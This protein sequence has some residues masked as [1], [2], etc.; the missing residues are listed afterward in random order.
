MTIFAIFSKQG[1]NMACGTQ[2]LQPQHHF[3][4]TRH[5]S[6]QSDTYFNLLYLNAGQQMRKLWLYFAQIRLI[7]SKFLVYYRP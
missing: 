5:H 6:G 3:S 2:N 4:E 1:V 7:F